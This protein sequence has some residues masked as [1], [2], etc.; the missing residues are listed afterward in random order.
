MTAATEV[1]VLHSPEPARAR[2]ALLVL[3]AVGISA[4]VQLIDRSYCVLVD[5]EDFENARREIE[6]YHQENPPAQPPPVLEPGKPAWG[7][8]IG[9]TL[10]L[11]AAAFALEL[12][13]GAAYTLAR[14]DALAIRTGEWGRLVTGL[15]LH[16]DLS[17]LL[18]NTG[19]GAAAIFFVART[20]GSI[21]ALSAA[22]WL[23]AA[24]NAINVLVRPT[25]HLS[26]GASTSVFAMLGLLGVFGWLMRTQPQYRWLTRLSPWLAAIALLGFTGTGGENTD[27]GAHLWGFAAGSLAGWPLY[28]NRTTLSRRPYVGVVVLA[29]G[30]L[31]LAAWTSVLI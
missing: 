30:S 6:T 3:D 5:V 12:S 9:F 28:R 27:L 1:T 13:A 11:W 24:G 22:L 20:S 16:A 18:A 19:F 4:T 31:F 26:I 14:V 21:V 8:A 2:E 10:A 29:S 7:A 25:G 15:F 17:H 23:G